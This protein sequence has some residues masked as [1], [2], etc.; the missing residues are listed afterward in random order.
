M[1]HVREIDIGRQVKLTQE[2]D[3]NYYP[4]T[5]A[6]AAAAE[7]TGSTAEATTA[8][9]PHDGPAGPTTFSDSKQFLDAPSPSRLNT[10]LST[11]HKQ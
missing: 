3:E 1:L 5:A 8:P 2:E 7:A 6:A 9:G 4:R 11:A 10:G